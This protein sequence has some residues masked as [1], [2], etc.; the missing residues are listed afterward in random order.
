MAKILLIEDQED[1][2][3]VMAMALKNR[4]HIVD[5]YADGESALQSLDK[6]WPEVA[7]VDSGL[8]GMSGID[9]GRAI[10]ARAENRDRILMALFTGT[11]TPEL[12]TR[13]VE[14]GFDLFV[15]KPI[16]INDFCARLDQLGFESS[17]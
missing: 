13:S 1:I 3:T 17:R 8:P 6:Q 4:G 7:I 15:V 12:Q 2:R 9:V 16:S 14:A 5:E 11:D 10:V